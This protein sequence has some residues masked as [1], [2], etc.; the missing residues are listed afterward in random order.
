ML[1]YEEAWQDAYNA[2]NGLKRSATQLMNAVN[3]INEGSVEGVAFNPDQL[4]ALKDQG[5]EGMVTA[6][7][8]Y[9][10]LLGILSLTQASLDTW[11][12]SNPVDRACYTTYLGVNCSPLATPTP[13]AGVTGPT[14]ETPITFLLTLLLNS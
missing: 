9:Q 3:T 4:E 12:I 2:G 1:H 7:D 14:E 8:Y 10:D 13:P 11:E 6:V 5:L